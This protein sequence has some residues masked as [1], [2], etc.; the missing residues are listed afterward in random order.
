MSVFVGFC[1]NGFLK[2]GWTEEDRDVVLDNLVKWISRRRTHIILVPALISNLKAM[3]EGPQLDSSDIDGCLEHGI[4]GMGN[5]LI[6]DPECGGG[7]VLDWDRYTLETYAP[8]NTKFHEEGRFARYQSSDGLYPSRL[9]GTYAFSQVK[10]TEE[11]G[12]V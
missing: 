10:A 7:F 2:M 4:L 8:C 9:V 12:L 6:L 11:L 1:Y 3:G 5:R